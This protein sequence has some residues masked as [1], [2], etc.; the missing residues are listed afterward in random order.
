MI[1]GIHR[2]A[3]GHVLRLLFYLLAVAAAAHSQAVES[4]EDYPYGKIVR[5]IRIRGLHNTKESLVRSQLISRIGCVY[6]KETEKQDRRWLERLKAFSSVRT[7]AMAVDDG[8]ILIIE[9]L[10]LPVFVPFPTL[11]VS[12]ENDASGGFGARLKNILQEAGVLSGSAKFGGLTEADLSLEAPWTRQTRGRY[13]I[14]YNYRDRINRDDSFR[15]NSHELDLKI[16]ISLHADWMLSG[17]FGFLSMGSNIPGVT[18]SPGGRDNTP[19]LGAVLEYDGRDSLFNPRDG[20]QGILD[21]TQNGGFLGG[22]GD[23]V[24]TRI[25]VRRYQPVASR[26]GLVFF[27]YAAFQS[28]AVGED[29]PEYRDYQI[30]GTNSVRGWDPNAR[31]GENQFLNTL[32]YRFELLPPR[33]LRISKYSFPIGL[34]LAGFAD[35]GTAWSQGSGFTRNMIAGGGFGLRVIAPFVNVVRLDLGFGQTGALLRP[36]IHLR[37]KAQYSRDRIR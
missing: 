9:I 20:W 16:G 28:G 22:E 8:V 21:I 14:K 6:T 29:V 30:G 27:S 25:D 23:F 32:E 5:D 11:N 31:R 13:S 12:S 19:A 26:H 1:Q 17:R 18:L 10:E 24:T 33:T 3:R 7:D 15:E 2:R 34:Q 35:L 37:E 4:P 36:H